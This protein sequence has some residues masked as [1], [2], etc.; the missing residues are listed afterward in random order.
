MPAPAA[1]ARTGQAGFTL[2]E[3]LVAVTLLAYV[4]TLLAGGLRLGLRAWETIEQRGGTIHN[5]QVVQHFLRHTLAEALPPNADD[6][7]EARIFDGERDRLAFVAPLP[8]HLGGGLHRLAVELA[9]GADGRALVLQ[10][11]PYHPRDPDAGEAETFVLL[12]RVERLELTYYESG[13]APGD[14]QWRDRW[15]DRPELPALVHINLTLDGDGRRL[16]PGLA[17]RPRLGRAL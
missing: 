7:L 3:L 14:G 10:L 6:P 8:A 1:T 2:L 15:Q 13:P 9:P 16:W 11:R 17:A 5:V 4:A 12:E